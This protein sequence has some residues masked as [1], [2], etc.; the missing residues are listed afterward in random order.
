MRKP[1]A[2]EGLVFMEEQRR[3]LGLLP[4]AVTRTKFANKGPDFTEER[5]QHLGLRDLLPAA[6]TSTESRT[7]RALAALHHKTRMVELYDTGSDRILSSE[8]EE[9]LQLELASY[10][11]S[12][13]S[14][15][16]NSSAIRT[17]DKRLSQPGARVVQEELENGEIAIVEDELRDQG[18]RIHRCVVISL[19]WV[20]N[21]ESTEFFTYRWFF[22][23][24][25]GY[26]VAL[27]A[28]LT[29]E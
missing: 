7:G 10:I 14:Q 26:V 2:N 17:Q 21:Y 25:T 4:V 1:I 23:L 12:A 28:C 6:V 5:R 24:P 20:S 8:T 13:A 19:V 11:K 22:V 3:Q 15:R 16:A 18:D 29:S 27:C 9:V